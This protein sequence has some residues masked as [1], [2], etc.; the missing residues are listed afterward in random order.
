[1]LNSYSKSNNAAN[2]QS[3]NIYTADYD[4]SRDRVEGRTRVEVIGV[5]HDITYAEVDS[6]DFMKP[7]IRT[8]YQD[9]RTIDAYAFLDTLQ[10]EAEVETLWGGEG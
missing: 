5:T 3:K 6:G 8:R 2:L 7:K 10:L 9:I 4:A 1:L